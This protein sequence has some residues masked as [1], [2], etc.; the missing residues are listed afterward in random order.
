MRSPSVIS[1][2]GIEVSFPVA[3]ASVDVANAT[4]GSESGKSS[5]I[6]AAGLLVSSLTATTSSCRRSSTF[7]PPRRRSIASMRYFHKRECH[8]NGDADDKC[9]KLYK[10]FFERRFALEFRNEIRAANINKR[11][12]GKGDHEMRDF[13]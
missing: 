1:R 7:P 12:C 8:H 13:F 5:V 2:A 9:K 11:A 4:R 6:S 10:G 3:K